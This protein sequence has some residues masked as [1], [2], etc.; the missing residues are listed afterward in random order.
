MPT[1]ART[2]ACLLVFATIGLCGAAHAGLPTPAPPAM[3][4]S[5]TP[6]PKPGF[7]RPL[8]S[9]LP[10]RERVFRALRRPAVVLVG[11]AATVGGTFLLYRLTGEP[12]LAV[13][14]GL[15]GLCGTLLA[16]ETLWGPDGY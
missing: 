3:S 11:T 13:P 7:L 15:V 2:L 10:T 4:R 8:L 9:R 5:T 16:A 1:P 6:S 12:R 14:G